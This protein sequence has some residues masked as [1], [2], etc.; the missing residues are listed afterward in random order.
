MAA[1]KNP[2]TKSVKSVS[3]PSPRKNLWMKCNDDI[4]IYMVNLWL[5]MVNNWNNNG[6]IYIY[7]YLGK[8]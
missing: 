5:I 7:I 4:Y 6:I 1:E 3:F 8:L 2:D